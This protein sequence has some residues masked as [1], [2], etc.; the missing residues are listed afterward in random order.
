ML[1][2]VGVLRDGYGN[3]RCFHLGGRERTLGF[4]RN[5]P[6]SYPFLI[7]I[8]P[9]QSKAADIGWFG[10]IRMYGHVLLIIRII[11]NNDIIRSCL[12][13]VEIIYKP[14]AGSIIRGWHYPDASVR[15]GKDF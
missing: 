4:F 15:Q 3:L 7:A 13:G 6:Y 14:I 9:T 11:G 1:A 12:T 8:R 2:Y 5:Q 10:I